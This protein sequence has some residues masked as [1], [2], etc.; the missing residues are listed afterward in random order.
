MKWHDVEQNSNEWLDLR[1]GKV[2][3]SKFG[4]IM[5]NFGRAFGQPAKDYALN[6]ALERIT[7]NRADPGYNN[8]HM[9][10]GHE[11]EPIARM[12][13]E[14]ENY[15]DVTNGGFFDCG[16]YGDSPDGLVGDDGVIEIKSVI[17]K[18]H[19]A[20]LRR[21]AQ[22]PAYKWQIIGHLD[23][24][25]RDW[26]DYV[27]YCSEFPEP[28]QLITHRIYAESCR[29]DIDNLRERREEFLTLVAS[30]K[31]EIKCHVH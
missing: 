18:V 31:K 9:E 12:L 16:S 27:S 15:V 8:S 25:G 19:Y 21:D 26:V 14:E 10:R 3:A 29:E 1:A 4:A 28:T 17:A 22:D 23:C 7:G 11:Q 5:A 2:T 6:I 30:I 24:S 20:T 13:Y